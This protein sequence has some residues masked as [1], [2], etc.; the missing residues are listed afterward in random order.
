MEK[1]IVVIAGP[2]GSGKNT[3]IEE[4][5][6]RYP[7]CVRTVTAT[8]RPPRSGERDG[9]DYHFLSKEEFE[10]AIL[11]GRIPEYRRVETLGTSYGTYLPDLEQKTR[12]GSIVFAQVDI[13]G[14]RYLKER[15]AATTIF[16]LPPSLETL[17]RRIEKRNP[18]MSAE[19]RAE[20][21]RIADREMREDVSFYDYS[22]ENDDNALGVSVE[23]IVAILR[24][25]G[26]TL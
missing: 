23:Q 5:A 14:A 6:K 8:T 25:E 24:K 10:K 11:D 13:V 3:V 17:M 20:R 1:R 16:I 19:E 12:E 2:S 26:Y 22:V 15:Y 18:H 9:V 4:I 7:K 21:M